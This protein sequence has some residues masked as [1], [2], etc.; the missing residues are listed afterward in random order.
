LRQAESRLLEN[1]RKRMGRKRREEGQPHRGEA[2][3]SSDGCKSPPVQIPQ[4][5]YSRT[6]SRR[7]GGEQD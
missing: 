3:L 2:R 6:E 1:V 5:Y 7:H 4:V